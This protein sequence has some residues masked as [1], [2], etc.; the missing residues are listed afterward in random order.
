MTMPKVVVDWRGGHQLRH[1][2]TQAHL[3]LTVPAKLSKPQR[4]LGPDVVLGS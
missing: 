4:L 3:P 2:A 1:I